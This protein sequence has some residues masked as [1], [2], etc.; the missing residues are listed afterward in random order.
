[1][2]KRYYWIKLKD[3]FME[4]DSIDFLMS[5][6]NGA[7]YVVL[8]QMLC[9][10]L[11]NTGGALIRK[12]GQVMIPYDAAKIQRDCKYFSLDTIMVA[13]ELYKNLGLIFE[14]ENGSLRISN[15]DN[16]IGS[17]GSS[18][19]RVRALRER[20]KSVASNTAVLESSL[21]CNADC[22][23][24]SNSEVLGE[25]TSDVAENA[26]HCNVDC[27]KNV[28]VD[29]R[30]RDYSLLKIKEI[31]DKFMHMG[32][33]IG[34][35]AHISSIVDEIAEVLADVCVSGKTLTFDGVKFSSADFD[36]VIEIIDIEVLSK[37][38]NSLLQHEECIADRKYYILGC[39][40]G[41]VKARKLW[42]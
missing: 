16:L 15:Y 22:N 39:I 14:D 20:N 9:L 36:T 29:I 19:S 37:V 40:V 24:N 23:A 11:M 35:N 13:L 30:E 6:K 5:Q 33:Y 32:A 18:A 38:V 34:G 28:T 1:M 10:K 41:E 31:K 3:S 17:E 42:K 8:Y 4:S 2:E 27:N 26:L 25:V 7:E 12:I 21:H